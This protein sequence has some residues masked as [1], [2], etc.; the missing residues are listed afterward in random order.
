MRFLTIF[1]THCIEEPSEDRLKEVILSAEE[2]RDYLDQKKE[3][4][5]LKKPWVRNANKD[6][7]LR[8]ARSHHGYRLLSIKETTEN[9]LPLPSFHK[10][11]HSYPVSLH[12]HPI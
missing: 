10:L 12:T 11:L 6:R 8:P 1:N 4:E 3:L 9:L 2:Y 7:N 5:K